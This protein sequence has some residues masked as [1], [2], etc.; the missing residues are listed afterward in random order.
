MVVNVGPI[1]AA[2]G[3]GRP[4]GSLAFVARGELGR[5]YRLD[6]VRGSW[7]IK[8]ILAFLPTSAEADAN[9]LGALLCRTTGPNAEEDPPPRCLPRERL[10]L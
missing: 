7:A 3:L 8:E 5:V 10:L 1:G 2:F 9:I 6:T 4:V